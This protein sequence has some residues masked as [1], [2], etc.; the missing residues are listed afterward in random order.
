MK[1]SKYSELAAKIVNCK[2]AQRAIIML[3]TAS[4]NMYLFLSGVFVSIAG[5][6][7]LESIN[8]KYIY[9]NRVYIALHFFLIVLSFIST[10]ILA[11]IANLMQRIDISNAKEYCRLTF[12]SNAA[13]DK[14]N[15]FENSLKEAYNISEDIENKHL[16][17]ALVWTFILRAICF[18]I[19]IICIALII[20]LTIIN[21]HLG[22]VFI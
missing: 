22:G 6:I 9:E 19:S 3:I 10:L 16:S 17:R 20:V 7:A 21:H 11:H 13:D 15:E 1:K 12:N 5:S 8:L 4:S 14:K 2:I 18:T